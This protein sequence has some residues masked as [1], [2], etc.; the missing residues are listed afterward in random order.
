MR[1]AL[2]NEY[3]FQDETRGYRKEGPGNIIRYVCSRVSP[4]SIVLALLGVLLGGH[5][6]VHGGCMHAG[7]IRADSPVMPSLIPCELI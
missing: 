7:C 2:A 5:G 1:R 4:S 6:S 3:T